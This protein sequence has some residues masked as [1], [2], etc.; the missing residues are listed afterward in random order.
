MFNKKGDH[1]DWALSMGI[2]LLYLIGLFILLRPGITPVYDSSGILQILETNLMNNITYEVREIPIIIKKCIGT[3]DSS[4]ESGFLPTIIKIEDTTEPKNFIFGTWDSIDSTAKK[5]IAG[6]ELKCGMDGTEP[7][8][9][10]ENTMYSI[11]YYQV[12]QGKV[13]ADVTAEC[14]PNDKK[15]CEFILGASITKTGVKEEWIRKLK[16]EIGK[17]KETYDELKKR[18]N[19]PIDFAIYEDNLNNKIIGGLEIEGV[20]IFAKEIKTNELSNSGT[21]TPKTIIIQVW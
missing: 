5:N 12:N 7:P 16:P 19:V 20:N 21:L 17:E 1:V 11:T 2:F 8:F 6:S 13:E 14:V 4:A 18:W 9:I 3:V 10:K 15:I